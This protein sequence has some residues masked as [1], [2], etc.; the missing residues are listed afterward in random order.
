MKFQKVFIYIFLAFLFLLSLNCNSSKKIKGPAVKEWT[1]FKIYADADDAPIFVRLQ[2]DLGIE[3]KLER[4]TVVV[5][6]RNKDSGY[7]YVIFGD[8]ESSNPPRFP[9]SRLS[10]EV[11]DGLINWTGSNKENLM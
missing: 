1:Y 10:K 4:Y 8:E 2:D 9:W 3:P 5:D 11:Q 6:I 7:W